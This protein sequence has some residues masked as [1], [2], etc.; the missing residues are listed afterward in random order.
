MA[1]I[2]WSS[3]KGLEPSKVPDPPKQVSTSDPY[4]HTPYGKGKLTGNEFIDPKMRLVFREFNP[5]VDHYFDSYKGRGLDPVQPNIYDA[6]K[7]SFA[8]FGSPPFN[9]SV[10]QPQQGHRCCVGEITRQ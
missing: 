6:P 9:N 5:S 1:Q 3:N 8:A 10:G 2:W 7:N 4:I